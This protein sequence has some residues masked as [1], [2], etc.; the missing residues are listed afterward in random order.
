MK[1]TQPINIIEEYELSRKA[2]WI[3]QVQKAHLESILN[4]YICLLGD[5]LVVNNPG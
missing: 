5:N 4:S 2:P 1:M 3:S